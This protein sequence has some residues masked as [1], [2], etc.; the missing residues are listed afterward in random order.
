MIINILLSIMNHEREEDRNMAAAVVFY[1]RSNNTR[2]AAGFLAEKLNAELVELVES[3]GR[4]GLLGFMKSGYQAVAKRSSK[5]EGKPW[6][7]TAGCKKLFLLTPIWGGNGTP[8]MK[9]FV[10]ETEFYG[11]EVIVVT[12]QSDV[13]RKGSEKVHNMYKEI[14]ENKGGKFIEGIALHSALPGKFAGKEYIETQVKDFIL[15]DD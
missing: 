8:A 13:Q 15:S 12:F 3:K 9:R 4:Q 10:E 11:K 5:L 2:T 1:S 6:E 14:I 7:K